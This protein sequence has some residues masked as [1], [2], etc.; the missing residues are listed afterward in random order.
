VTFAVDDSNLTLR[1]DWR[2]RGENNLDFLVVHLVSTSTNPVAGTYLTT[3][4]IGLSQYNLRDTFATA[5]IAIAGTN[6]GTTKRLVFSWT[7]S[8]VGGDQPPGAI[9]N[10]SLTSAKTSVTA[11]DASGRTVPERFALEQNYPNP[12]N[13]TTMIT[14]AL[15]T[16]AH[17]T[18]KI[19]DLLGRE[20]AVLVDGA[21]QPGEYSVQ[22]TGEGLQSGVYF[23]RLSAGSFVDTKKLLLIK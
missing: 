10:I 15:P 6:R 1:F 18:L 8:L 3:G 2:C 13:P 19:F 12:F 14:F 7:N 5:T 21:K 9:D 23:Y 22:W 17:A 11:A 20:I 4:L 16:Q